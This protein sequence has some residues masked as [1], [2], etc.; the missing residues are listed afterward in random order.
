MS[1]TDRVD[2]YRREKFLRSVD[3]SYGLPDPEPSDRLPESLAGA[4][5]SDGL[6]DDPIESSVSELTAAHYDRLETELFGAWRAGYDYLHVWTTI[7]KKPAGRLDPFYVSE[8]FLPSNVPDPECP[9][10]ATPR[11]TYDLS[12]I[13]DHVMR[14]AW[15]DDLDKYERLSAGP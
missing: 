3:P 13:P 2:N 7:Q 5:L 11:E 4:S 15:R 8:V 14:A 1:N 6:G 9:P 10:T 12:A